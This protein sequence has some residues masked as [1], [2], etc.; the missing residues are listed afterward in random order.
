MPAQGS[1]V[2][3]KKESGVRRNA[4]LYSRLTPDPLAVATSLRL[5][6]HP[7]DLAVSKDFP[8]FV[9]GL[10]TWFGAWGMQTVL[11]SWLVVGELHAS[12]EW[13]SVAQTASM[14]P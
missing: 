11:F 12:A 7:L 3:R 14:L 2:D 5:C 1:A 4:P 10:A 8:W 9:A 13:V 6:V